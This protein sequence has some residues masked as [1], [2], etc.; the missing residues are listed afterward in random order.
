VN[1]LT[2]KFILDNNPNQIERNVCCLNINEGGVGMINIDNIVKS[3]HIKFICRIINNEMDSWNGIIG[4]HWL[5]KYDNKFGFV[6][7]SL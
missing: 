3:K 2:C 5:Q 6:F 7:F 1:D 4:K